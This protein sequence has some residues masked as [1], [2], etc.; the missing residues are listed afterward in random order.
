MADERRERELQRFSSNQETQIRTACLIW[1]DETQ[2]EN[3][4]D[5]E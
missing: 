2:K 4:T 5:R 3:D 1:R